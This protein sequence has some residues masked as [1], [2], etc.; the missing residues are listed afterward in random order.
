MGHVAKG[1]GTVNK[2]KGQYASFAVQQSSILHGSRVH[3][4]SV[5]V[6]GVRRNT[7]GIEGA[8][9]MGAI[10]GWSWPVA[11]LTGMVWH[12]PVWPPGLLHSAL[13]A[14]L[15]VFLSYQHLTLE[16]CLSTQVSLQHPKE[17]PHWR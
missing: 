12:R 6:G 3:A 8:G 10:G 11:G 13:N 5:G 1:A 4:D 9:C 15:T 14:K 17:V 2:A 7:A 16:L